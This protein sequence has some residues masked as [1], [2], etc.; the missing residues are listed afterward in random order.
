MTQHTVSGRGFIHADPI[1]G[2][3]NCVVRVYRSSALPS[4]YWPLRTGDGS[5]IQGEA[6]GP[7]IWLRVSEA[8]FGS[9]LKEAHAHLPLD[10]ARK[11]RDALTFLIEEAEA[12]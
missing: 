3:D 12:R 2:T 4:I 9:E 8:P 11:V 6:K 10:A 1:E 7:F 5:V